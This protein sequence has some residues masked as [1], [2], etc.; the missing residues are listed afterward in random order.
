MKAVV[1][2]V[3]VC[4]MLGASNASAEA[5]HRAI[6][7][8]VKH[9]PGVMRAH[10]V[11]VPALTAISITVVRQSGTC[12]VKVRAGTGTRGAGTSRQVANILASF[13][14]RVHRA[15]IV[16]LPPTQQARRLHITFDKRSRDCRFIS[17]VI[18]SHIGE[19]AAEAFAKSIVQLML[20]D[21]IGSMLGQEPGDLTGNPLVS[22]G[23]GA[24]MAVLMNDNVA[25]A[26]A[27]VML[28]EIQTQV[29]QAIPESHALAVFVTHVLSGLMSDLYDPYFRAQGASYR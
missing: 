10:Y 8:Y 14:E 18:G 25:A 17:F 22:R 11:D 15:S 23:I 5:F 7:T 6:N 29:S 21:M 19:K 9:I 20:E 3:C 12:D 2:S 26:G 27:S 28:N 4:L 16:V 1:L 24:G 13:D